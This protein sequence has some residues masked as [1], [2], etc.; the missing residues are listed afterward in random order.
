MTWQNLRVSAPGNE[1][2]VARPYLQ[3]Q[4]LGSG[5]RLCATQS[6]EAYNFAEIQGGWNAEEPHGYP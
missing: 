1:R 2:A 4:T 5:K 3:E 6:Q